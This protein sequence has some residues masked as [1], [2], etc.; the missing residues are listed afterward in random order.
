MKCCKGH[1][2]S[3]VIDN[4]ARRTF[5]VGGKNHANDKKSE[6]HEL[7]ELKNQTKADKKRK[8]TAKI[9]KLQSSRL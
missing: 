1:E 5:N 3:K 6:I 8:A 7:R 2:F 4:V 9:A